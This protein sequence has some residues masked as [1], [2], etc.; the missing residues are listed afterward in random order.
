MPDT[1]E[2]DQAPGGAIAPEDIGYDPRAGSRVA[3]PPDPNA[4]PDI[5]PFL[6]NPYQGEHAPLPSEGGPIPEK[7]WLPQPPQGSQQPGFS[8]TPYIKDILMSKFAGSKEAGVAIQRALQLEGRLGFDADVKAGLP[9]GEAMAKWG[10]KLYADN[11][12]AVAHFAAMQSARQ[13]PLGQIMDLGEGRQGVRVGPQHIQLLPPKPQTGPIQGRSILD[14]QGNV[15][16][17]DA[18]GARHPHFNTNKG[19]ATLR[20]Q[21]M[22]FNAKLKASSAALKAAQSTPGPEG[23]KLTQDL[24]R[25]HRALQT[26]LGKLGV[27]PTGQIAPAPEKKDRKAGATYMTPNGVHQWTGSH[28]TVPMSAPADERDYPEVD[29]DT[30]E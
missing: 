28:W 29:T 22:L 20:D 12:S 15:I 18:E 16:G 4:A 21:I 30:E 14:D 24:L 1:L 23:R 6:P 13:A 27:T 19:G 17:I 11:P 7:W 25:E 3:A 10:D 26:E 5:Q 8:A 9:P 2:E